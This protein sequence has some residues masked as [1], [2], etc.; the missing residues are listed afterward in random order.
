M[1]SPEYITWLHSSVEIKLPKQQ[2]HFPNE[3]SVVC[4]IYL[5][6]SLKACSSSLVKSY[7]FTFDMYG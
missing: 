1:E 4:K 6:K 7:H 3:S 5:K 2:S